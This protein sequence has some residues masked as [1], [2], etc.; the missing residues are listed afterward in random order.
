MSFHETFKL[1][2]VDLQQKETRPHECSEAI[3]ILWDKLCFASALLGIR[4]EHCA[5]L[6]IFDERKA[7]TIVSMHS[8][9]I[10]CKCAENKVFSY[11]FADCGHRLL[12]NEM[13]GGRQTRPNQSWLEKS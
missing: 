4:A 6:R 2:V 13:K 7:V 12:C 11:I 5:K 1:C 10:C 3:S 9:K 8:G